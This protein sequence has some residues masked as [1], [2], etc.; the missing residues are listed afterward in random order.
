MLPV[1][2]G[3]P[4]HA[5]GPPATGP[6]APA[7]AVFPLQATCV[8][9]TG[10]PPVGGGRCQRG[11]RGFPGVPGCPPPL[12]G[13]QPGLGS[14]V[15]S[16]EPPRPVWVPLGAG[17]GREEGW[18]GV[19]SA[20]PRPWQ[21]SG[22]P[23]APGHLAAAGGAR[24]PI[25]PDVPGAGLRSRLGGGSAAGHR[26]GIVPG[27]GPPSPPAGPPPA[28]AHAP[29]WGWV[30]QPAGHPSS[31]RLS[32]RPAW[33]MGPSPSYPGLRVPALRVWL[34]GLRAWGLGWDSGPGSPCTSRMG[35]HAPRSP[36]P[37]GSA[38]H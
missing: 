28:D 23:R 33:G 38:C 18:P 10:K 8:L 13:D 31:R 27:P 34:P 4:A 20:E 32:P 6:E 36:S 2:P 15:G 30:G 25:S 19:P 26:Q 7:T 3:I 9:V 5:P 37:E 17:R 22:L 14:V 24:C 1:G 12:P 21:G 11:F 16:P 35:R 29:S